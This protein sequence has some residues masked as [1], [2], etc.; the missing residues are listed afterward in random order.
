M[1]VDV[2]AD[3]GGAHV[4]PAIDP[5]TMPTGV[6]HPNQILMLDH[7]WRPARRSST[8]PE[9]PGTADFPP[10]PARKASLV[11]DSLNDGENEG[12]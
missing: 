9:S 11:H 8:E 1:D 5:I 2:D 12:S 6:G 3:V 7:R 10:G 4:R